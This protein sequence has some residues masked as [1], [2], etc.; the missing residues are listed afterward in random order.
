MVLFPL[1]CVPFVFY[2]AL[3]F[4]TEVHF[5]VSKILSPALLYTTSYLKGKKAMPQSKF[6]I[7][8]YK[9]KLLLAIR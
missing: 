8:I 4:Y 2:I 9:R 6:N 1:N 3:C 5:I 7:Y